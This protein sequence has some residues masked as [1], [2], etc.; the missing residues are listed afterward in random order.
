MPRHPAAMGRRRRETGA[1]LAL[2]LAVAAALVVAVSA[3][4]DW[5]GQGPRASGATAVADARPVTVSPGLPTAELVPRADA[6]V[7]VDLFNANPFPVHVRSLSLDTARG[8]A[9]VDVDSAHTGCD[10]SVLRFTTQTHGPPGWSIPASGVLS[11]DLS[12]ALAM[13]VS[14]AGACQGASFLVHLRVGT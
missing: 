13:D 11:I 8:S 5:T 14:A 4:A 9:G 6:D 10:T 12:H 2:V 7:A 3:L 1:A